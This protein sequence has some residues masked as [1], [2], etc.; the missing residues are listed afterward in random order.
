MEFSPLAQGIVNGLLIGGLYALM[1]MGVAMIFGTM[2]VVNFAHGEFVML[3]MFATYWFHYYTQRDPLLVALAVVPLLYLFGVLVQKTLIERIVEESHETQIIMTLGISTLLLNGAL[4]LWGPE[5][6]SVRT[7]YTFSVWDTGIVQIPVPR[8]V[9]F[10]MAVLLSAALWLFLTRSDLGRAL[11]A[12]AEN[13]EWAILMGIPTAHV[14]AM[15]FGIGIALA[16]AAGA[17]ITPFFN[18]YPR[19]G[20]FF[21]LIAYIVT[22]LGGMG[23]ILGAAVAGLVV[24]VVESLTAQFLAIDLSLLGVFII[25]ILVLLFQPT[26][27]LGRGRRY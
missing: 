3:G 7:A 17:L 15:S 27:I 10:L 2:N 9:A 26:G 11:R 18:T 13:R 16:A 4:L 12:T 24:G 8:L 23:N 22:V 6:R 14:N 25:F 19:A 21:G 20:A 1:A 5:Y